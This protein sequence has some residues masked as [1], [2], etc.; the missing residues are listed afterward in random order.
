MLRTVSVLLLLALVSGLVRFQLKRTTSIVDDLISSRSYDTINVLREN[1]W[2]KVEAGGKTQIILSD[3]MNAQYFGEVGIG[4]PPQMFRVIFD[5]GSSNLWVPSQHCSLLNI[6]CK[7]HRRYK[8][9]A[10]STFQKNGTAFSIQYGTGSLT[11]YISEDNVLMGDMTVKG[12]LFAEAIHEPGYTFIAAKFDGILGMG[13][14]YI[15][16]TGAP[17]VFTNMVDQGL[18]A[19]PVFAFW[20]NREQG[21][22]QGGEL[23]LGGTD[24]AHYTG[25]ITWTKVTL[26]AYW[27]F[28]VDSMMFGEEDLCAG[29]CKAIADTGTS[30]MT[31][32]TDEVAKIYKATGV[33][34]IK[35][36]A[37]MDCTKISSLPTFTI[38]ISGTK[39][40]LTPEQ[41][42]LKVTELGQTECLL[43]IMAMDIPAPAGPLWILGDV[44]HGPYYTV[45]DVGN[46]RVGFANAA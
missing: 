29:G 19:E 22:A 32:P 28:S 17:P 30:M 15:A 36:I 23:T 24:T 20:L 18:V 1:T 42:V 12:Q 35:G 5:T 9:S 16:V 26:P 21:A 39:F 6:A 45:Y 38:T 11:G 13:F 31:G 33:T 3:V 2:R 43:G 8:D 10:S 44:F 4:T 40:P 34:P 25:N 37:I 14:P 46:S 41:Y 27:E 7:T